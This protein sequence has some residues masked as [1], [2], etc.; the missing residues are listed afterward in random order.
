MAQVTGKPLHH[1]LNQHLCNTTSPVTGKVPG[2]V[3]SLDCGAGWRGS[4]LLQKGAN[5]A[6]AVCTFHARGQP[7]QTSHCETEGQDA[8]AGQGEPVAA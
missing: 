4:W 7:R 8:S 6:L 3:I 1:D 2:G 5:T